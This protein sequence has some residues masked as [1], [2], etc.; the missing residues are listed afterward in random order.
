MFVP[1]WSTRTRHHHTRT[2][3]QAQRGASVGA[4]PLLER[5]CTR[6]PAPIGSIASSRRRR[7]RTLANRWSTCTTNAGIPAGRS[8]TVR[9]N[10][11][12]SRGRNAAHASKQCRTCLIVGDPSPDTCEH[13]G[14]HKFSPQVH[15]RRPT[16]KRL[17]RRH[18]DPQT[19]IPTLA[20]GDSTSHAKGREQ[21]PVQHKCHMR[22]ATN[23]LPGSATK[24]T[25]CTLVLIG[26]RRTR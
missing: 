1:T 19:W 9:V 18:S 3:T 4:P 17:P 26:A 6:L 22:T 11:D 13:S 5:E 10:S 21:R 7:S 2:R 20:T 16:A 12:H 24:C 25:V 8:S 14:T 23:H 15:E